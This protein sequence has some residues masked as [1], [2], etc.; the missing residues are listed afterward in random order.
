M[1]ESIAYRGSLQDEKVEGGI[2]TDDVEKLLEFQVDQMQ[3][4]Y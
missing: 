1:F 2:S 4:M 3:S